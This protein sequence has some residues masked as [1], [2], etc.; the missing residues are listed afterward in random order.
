MHLWLSLVLSLIVS[1]TCFSQEGNYFLRHYVS[2]DKGYDNIHF[3]IVQDQNGIISI[4]NRSGLLRFDGKSWEHIKTPSVVFSLSVS[5][6][7]N[8]FIGGASGFGQLIRNQKFNLEYKSLSDKEKSATNITK[9]LSL[10]DSLFAINDNH[11][12]VYTQGE[13]KTI[14]SNSSDAFVD[15]FAYKKKIFV[16]N[17][18]NELQELKGDHLKEVSNFPGPTK[19]VRFLSKSRQSPLYLLGTTDQ[20]LMLI[21]QHKLIP[22]TFD[23]DNEYLEQSDIQEGHFLSDSLVAISTLKGGVIFINPI[24]KKIL[25]I[26]NYQSGLPDNQIFAITTD[27]QMG[28][29]VAHSQ[30]LSRIAPHSPF[31]NFS[32]YPGLKGN[33]LSATKHENQLYVGTSTGVYYLDKIKN[34][35]RNV[36]YVKK[37]IAITPTP[38]PEEKKKKHKG[39]FSFLKKKNNENEEAST[40]Q[41]AK[42]QIQYER[43]VEKVLRSITYEYKPVS[44]IKSKAALFGSDGSRLFCGS[45][46]GLFE[47]KNNK[48]I[49]IYD[50]PIRFFYISPKHKKLFVST[51][52]HSLKV[53][54]YSK[55]GVS[56]IRLFEDFRD[57]VHYI[58]EDA[59]GLIWFCSMENIY[60]IK[61]QNEEIIETKEYPISNPYYD[62]I[63]GIAH[64]DTI[65]V[66][67]QQGIFTLDKKEDRFTLQAKT[68]NIAEYFHASDKNIWYRVNQQWH[69]LGE[70]KEGSDLTILNLFNNIQYISA[71]ESDR[72]IWLVTG[73]NELY[74]ISSNKINEESE[75][76]RLFLK[77]IKAGEEMYGPAP[78][79]KF[80][81]QNSKL[82]FE[83]VQPD[84][85][86]IM[87]I[88]YRY[89]LDGLNK[90]WSEWSTS[91]NKIDFPYL[92]DGEYTLHVR[93]KNAF[94]TINETEPIEFKIIPPYWKR[95]WFY[96]FEVVGLAFLLFISIN[97]KKLGSKYRVVSQLI[98]V[99]ALIII[100][101]FIQTVAESEFMLSSPVIDFII[102]VIIAIIILPI[103]GF[104]RRYIFKEEI[105]VID[106]VKW[107]NKKAKT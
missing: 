36:N 94:G 14:I 83:F 100:I 29:W 87:D 62:E 91:Y 27:Q 98:A 54:D 51:Y 17:I 31:K 15:L 63:Y 41:K 53:F 44:N 80:N 93:S 23:A 6:N 69:K 47:I 2:K 30:G 7:N 49:K 103:E 71:N 48:A 106:F 25:Q 13:I 101:E 38:I 55:K 5:E 39:F 88:Q 24:K 64:N 20:K 59:E 35:D 10:R 16:K 42:T 22:I 11:L 1:I 81:Q 72:E 84:Y 86:G 68:N 85:S 79:L 105:D 9:V 89:K 40:I 50:E 99:L 76:Y 46:D 45:L 95:P 97:I 32:D 33:I 58:F 60:W 18:R 82:I 43:R 28:A 73:R 70:Q 107:K 102:Q 56:D 67:N 66:L 8:L 74:L 21:W 78:Q 37:K 52:D 90:E 75:N 4:A 104:L 26:V 12:Y 3:D 65:F 19:N 77:D 34:F 92:P 96:V 61:L 57:N